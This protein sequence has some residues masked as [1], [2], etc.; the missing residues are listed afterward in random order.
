[1][2]EHVLMWQERQLSVSGGCVDLSL[3]AAEAV[4]AGRS[5]M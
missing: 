4:R 5:G 1:M 2:R 3:A